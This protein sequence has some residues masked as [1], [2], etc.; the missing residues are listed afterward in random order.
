LEYNLTGG[1]KDYAYTIDRIIGCFRFI[2]LPYLSEE[3]TEVE[4]SD[5]GNCLIC[6]GSIY[7]NSGIFS[8]YSGQETYRTLRCHNRDGIL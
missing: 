8:V 2:Y 3:S 1:Y 7:D 6:F 5:I 4:K